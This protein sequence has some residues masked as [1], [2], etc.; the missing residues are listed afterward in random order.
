MENAKT[1]IKFLA[2]QAK[3]MHH[4]KSLRFKILNFKM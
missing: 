4:Y 3:S 1:T 2:G